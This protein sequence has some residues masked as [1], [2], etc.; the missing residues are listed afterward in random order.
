[1]PKQFAEIKNGKVK[2]VIVVSDQDAPDEETGI[3][4]CENLYGGLWEPDRKGLT[5]AGV[6]DAF[7]SGKDAFIKPQP[8]HSWVLDK[9]CLW[10]APIP[11]PDNK[12]YLWDEDKQEWTEERG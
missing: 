3:A 4:F 5:I 8:Y 7:D 9:D 11:M 1:M 2:R 10:Q 6:G 12:I